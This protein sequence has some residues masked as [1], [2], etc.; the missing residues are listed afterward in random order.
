VVA[1]GG[2][3]HLHF[4]GPFGEHFSYG[5]TTHSARQTLNDG[6]HVTTVTAGAAGLQIYGHTGRGDAVGDESG[7]DG[8]HLGHAARCCL[9]SRCAT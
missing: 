3:A 8:A 7:D 1:S 2:H 5:H 4:A 9:R 6:P